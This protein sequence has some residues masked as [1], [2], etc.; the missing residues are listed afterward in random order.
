MIIFSNIKLYKYNIN[1]RYIFYDFFHILLIMFVKNKIFHKKKIAKL[2]KRTQNTKQVNKKLLLDVNTYYVYTLALQV[3]KQ[4]TCLNNYIINFQILILG[5][6]FLIE[7][8]S[9]TFITKNILNL[10]LY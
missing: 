10:T 5:K 7:K 2:Y 4:F 1:K 3:Y 9:S 6:L 8:F